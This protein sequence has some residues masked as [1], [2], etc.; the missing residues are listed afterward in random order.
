MRGARDQNLAGN[1][2]PIP[3]GKY[4]VIYAD[5]PWRYDFAASNNRAIENQYP[6]MTV[7]ELAALP[8]S[9]AADENCVLYLWATNPKLREALAII[10]A[11]GFT[12]KTNLVW[13]KDR[14]GMGYWARQRHELLLVATKGNP[15]VPH[16]SLR[17]D[18]VIEAPRSQHSAKPAEA[19]E[20]I[21]RCFPRVPKVELFCRTPR[22][23]W[24]VFGNEVAE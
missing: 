15:S 1:A 19:A 21:E 5:P 16:E 18:S 6:T 4:G 10:D 12:Y 2:T 22:D 3:A 23:G 8:V 11:W 7:E 24:A 14:V 13:V 9:D 20:I 17:P